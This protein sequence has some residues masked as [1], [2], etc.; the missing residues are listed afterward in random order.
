MPATCARPGPS[1]S[2]QVRDQWRREVLSL[3]AVPVVLRILD[4]LKRVAAL[5]T[6]AVRNSHV[7][8]G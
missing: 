5:L 3:T 8:R 2:R 6:V 1:L 4:G 7:A